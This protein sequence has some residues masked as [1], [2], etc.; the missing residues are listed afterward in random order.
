M[1]SFR[2]PHHRLEQ[3]HQWQKAHGMERTGTAL[4]ALLAVGLEREA[5]KPLPPPARRGLINGWWR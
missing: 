3:V 5:A 4:N 2:I 1:M